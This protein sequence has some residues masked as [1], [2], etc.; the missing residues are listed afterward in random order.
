[1]ET[2]LRLSKSDKQDQ[3]IKLAA[4]IEKAKA[5]IANARSL[6]LDKEIDATEYKEI[7]AEYEGEITKLERNIEELTTLDS[8]LKEHIAFCCELFQNLPKYFVAV[9]LMAKQQIIGSILQEKLVFSENQYRTIKFRN[10]ISLIC[11][12]G[13]DYRGGRKKESPENSELSTLVPGT[14]F[15]PAHLAALPPEDS[16]STNFATRALPESFHQRVANIYK[17]M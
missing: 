8:N 17:L 13:K 4:E 7:M 3:K 2:H 6:M 14:G 12:P 11:R 5:R 15:E 1:M 10:V 16:A 9:D